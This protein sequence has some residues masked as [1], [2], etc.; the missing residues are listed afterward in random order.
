LEQRREILRAIWSHPH[1]NSNSNCKPYSDTY[2]NGY[3]N[4]D[5]HY[6]ADP[7]RHDHS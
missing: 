1:T 5:A 7:D 2:D 3:T 4:N 6:N